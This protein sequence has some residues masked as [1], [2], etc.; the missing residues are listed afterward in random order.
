[1]KNYLKIRELNKDDV[2]I[3]LLAWLL[4]DHFY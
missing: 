4:S 1:M 2:N 3:M